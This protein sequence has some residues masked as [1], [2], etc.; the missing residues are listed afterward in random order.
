MTQTH[1]KRLIKEVKEAI[2]KRELIA[3]YYNGLLEE[4]TTDEQIKGIEVA[5]NKDKQAQIADTKWLE[6]LQ[7]KVK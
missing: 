4:A 5:I 1:L 3:E 6:F 2:A 7:T